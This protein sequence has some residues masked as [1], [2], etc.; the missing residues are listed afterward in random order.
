M[1]YKD[2]Q[3][4]ALRKEVERLTDEN[5]CQKWRLEYQEQIIKKLQ[6]HEPIQ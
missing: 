4:E 1:N 6:E 3:I 2:A 5:K